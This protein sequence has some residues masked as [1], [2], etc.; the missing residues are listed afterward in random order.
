MTQFKI[1]TSEVF[2]HLPAS[3]QQ[4]HAGHSVVRITCVDEDRT[5][6]VK[7][8]AYVSFL[9]QA[10]EKVFNDISYT[11]KP[12]DS[13]RLDWIFNGIAENTVAAAMA[14]E[15]VFKLIAEWARSRKGVASKNSYCLGTSQELCTMGKEARR[16]E[17]E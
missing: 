11:S 13:R 17:E 7:Y 10:M 9:A 2:A 16:L 6:P 3:D 5:K 4:K 14:F 15:M 12:K 8:F 1:N